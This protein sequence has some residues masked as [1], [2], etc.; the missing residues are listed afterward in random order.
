MGRALVGRTSR[1]AADLP[2]SLLRPTSA[3]EKPA[4]P[5]FFNGVP[6]RLR[7]TNGDEKPPAERYSL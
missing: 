1:S 5:R 7:R 6:M 3:D 2:V 4:C